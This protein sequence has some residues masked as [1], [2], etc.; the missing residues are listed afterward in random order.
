MRMGTTMRTRSGRTSA[1]GFTLVELMISL[2]IG[3]LVIAGVFTVF[4]ASRTSY[5]QNEAQSRVQENARIALE[6]LSSDL[7]HAAFMGCRRFGANDIRVNDADVPLA[8]VDLV[9]ERA[10]RAEP[11]GLDG[12][13]EIRIMGA[14]E[15]GTRLGG[16]V[17][18]VVTPGDLSIELLNTTRVP[19]QAMGVA[20][21]NGDLATETRFGLITDC[22]K[23]DLFQLRS[24]PIV[25]V[26]N[27]KV[28]LEL[29]QTLNY[30]YGA[31]AMVFPLKQ[32]VYRIQ[33]SGRMDNSDAEIPSLF[34]STDGVN[35]QEIA[36]GVED[37]VVEYGED[38][39]GNGS[40]D[41]Y[42]AIGDATPPS[43]ARV[44]VVR[45]RLL[46]V[47]AQ[48]FVLETEQTYLFDGEEEEAEEGDRRY[49]QEF[50]AAVGLR[51]RLR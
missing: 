6:L 33:G 42:V 34:R 45:A 26:P 16:G 44:V 2:I 49:R 40:V 32:V 5:T 29:D 51:N 23:G 25:S 17:G 18:N 30:G 31:D 15:D 47:S 1:R 28:T 41:H 36:E 19:G 8:E 11:G 12:T 48:N 21:G 22:T 20:M 4:F 43:W 13:D 35:F 37:L 38:T 39:D 24:D 9:E 27:N 46:F 3:L 10:I 50:T 14:M 7:R